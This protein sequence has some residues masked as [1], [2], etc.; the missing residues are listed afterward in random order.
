[1]KIGLYSEYAR[2]SIVKIRKEAREARLSA[3]A[4]SIKMFREKIKQSDNSH[5]Q[6]VQSFLDFY[7]MSNVRDLLFHV[8]EHRFTL[9]QIQTIMQKLGLVFC[10]FE[11][12]K[13]TFHAFQ[14]DFEEQSARF[15]LQA[16][17]YFEQ[18]NPKA[19]RGMYQF[20]CQKI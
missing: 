4:G 2:T 13:Q 18:K 12:S 1:M 19:F 6:D 8:Q 16:W 9:P 20:W 11:A 15:S 10:G 17:D 5:H 14:A 7:S 3:D